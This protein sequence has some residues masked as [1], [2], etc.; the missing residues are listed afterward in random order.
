MYPAR[1]GHEPSPRTPM[2][3]QQSSIGASVSASNDDG[4]SKAEAASKC[5]AVSAASN[6]T[7]CWSRGSL[8]AASRCTFSTFGAR[9]QQLR[10]RTIAFQPEHGGKMRQRFA[11]PG[12]K[13]KRTF[14]KTSRVA[15]L[16]SRIG[17]HAE[18]VVGVGAGRMRVEI[19]SR[20]VAGFEQGAGIGKCPGLFERARFGCSL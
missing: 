6:R 8:M 13:I 9:Q 12:V 17:D 1:R 14:V 11:M 4:S 10:A 20:D 19:A 5:P 15:L 18:Q 2:R 3:F 16:T 7:S